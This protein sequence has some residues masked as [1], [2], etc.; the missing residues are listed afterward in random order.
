MF[1]RTSLMY[2]ITWAIK[3]QRFFSSL[4]AKTDVFRRAKSLSWRQR[5]KIHLTCSDVYS[6]SVIRKIMFLHF[7][8]VSLN[9]SHLWFSLMIIPPNHFFLIY[10]ISF[11]CFLPTLH[12]PCTYFPVI[13][14]SFLSPS[15]C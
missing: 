8:H 4:K 9:P 7:Q 12:I 1:I 3:F 15:S 6:Y 5:Q 14:F 2:I 10:V 11:F 13:V